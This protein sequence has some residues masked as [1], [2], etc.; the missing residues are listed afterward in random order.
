MA[1]VTAARSLA[2]S[3]AQTCGLATGVDGLAVVAAFM[4][5]PPCCGGW[6]H[7]LEGRD[8]LFNGSDAQDRGSADR[9]AREMGGGDRDVPD[10]AGKDLDLT[11]PDMSGE[12]GQSRQLQCPAEEGMAGIG[13]GDFPLAFL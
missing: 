6:A 10:L 5:V 7:S 4:A 12:V 8:E 3:R 9:P 1:S 2:G 13:D 11:V